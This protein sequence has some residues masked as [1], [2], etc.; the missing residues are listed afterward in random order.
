MKGTL[1]F[2]IKPAA[3]AQKVSLAGDFSSWK[4]LEMRK[5]K[6]GQFVAEVPARPGTYEYKF[7][8]DGQW[9]SDPDNNQRKPNRFG[10]ENSVAT[11]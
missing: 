2:S 7:V 11:A 1:K 5:Q 9:I 3:S 6:D 10:S 4:P 8:V